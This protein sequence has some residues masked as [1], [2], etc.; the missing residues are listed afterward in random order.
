MDEGL[1][2]HYVPFFSW[3]K[4]HDYR[5]N[6]LSWKIHSYKAQTGTRGSAGVFT[7]HDSACHMRG[8][9]PL[10]HISSRPH[11]PHCIHY[12]PNIRPST[13]HATKKIKPPLRQVAP[14]TE[15]I[16]M[17]L[18][19]VNIGNIIALITHAITGKNNENMA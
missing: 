11:Q 6:N 13:P 14:S 2:K 12:L 15:I 1:K 16:P 9:I 18:Q 4:N 5:T 7:D 19:H 17:I 10:C 8:K 3:L